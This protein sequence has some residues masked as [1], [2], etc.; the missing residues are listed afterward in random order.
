MTQA[1]VAS[2]K[3]QGFC[4]VGGSQ[5]GFSPRPYAEGRRRCCPGE[6]QAGN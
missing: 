3:R 4:G 2:H 6:G 1:E 5:E